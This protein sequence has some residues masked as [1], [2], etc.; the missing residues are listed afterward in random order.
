MFLTMSVIV[1]G[2]LWHAVLALDTP[3]NCTCFGCDLWWT[4]VCLCICLTFNMSS[5]KLVFIYF[6]LWLGSHL[7][8]LFRH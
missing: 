5:V 7:I 1:D 6:Y 8:L 4:C 3:A 2:S